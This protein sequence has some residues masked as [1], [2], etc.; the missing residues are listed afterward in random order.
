MNLSLGSSELW[1]PTAHVD[2]LTCY[3]LRNLD[4]HVLYDTEKLKITPMWRNKRIGND[5]I[6]ERLD[7]WFLILCFHMLSN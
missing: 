1:G 3:F 5:R 4:D 2:S 6:E 7:V